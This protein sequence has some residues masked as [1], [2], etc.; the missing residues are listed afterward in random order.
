MDM[1]GEDCESVWK[2][3]NGGYGIQ[4]AARAQGRT[5]ARKSKKELK[6]KEVAGALQADRWRE[7]LPGN[8]SHAERESM[9]A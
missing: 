7:D 2:C 9:E 5:R 6:F 8:G 3:H 1:L 4:M